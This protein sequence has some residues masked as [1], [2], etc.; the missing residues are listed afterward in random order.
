MNK[1]FWCVAGIVVAI[2]RLTK[3]IIV[4][5]MEILESIPVIPGL[6][7]ITHI[8]NPGA[9]F[10]LFRDARALFLMIS[11]VVILAVI[12][13]S[14]R[15]ERDQKLLSIGLGLTLAGAFGNMI[16]RL[17]RGLVVDFLDFRIWPVFNVADSAIVVGSAIVVY[18]LLKM[19]V[20]PRGR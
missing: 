20:E 16:D 14:H 3:W 6:F 10:G 17:T 11:L 5:N 1:L 15:V 12:W 8:Q 2:D 4:S 9:A 18:F 13:Y 19:P 7:H